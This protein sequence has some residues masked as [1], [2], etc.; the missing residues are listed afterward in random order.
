MR[1]FELFAAA[2]ALATAT[3]AF[4]ADTAVATATP[5]FGVDT[6]VKPDASGGTSVSV[7]SGIDYSTGKYGEAK[8]TD[9]L[10]GLTNLSV[11]SHDFT[12]SASLPYLTIAGPAFVV[13]GPGG[14][15]VL[16]KPRPGTDSAGRSGW[17]DLSLGV[18]YTLPAELLDDFEVAVTE[19]TK[20]ATADASKGLSTGATDFS[21][22]VDVSRQ[23]DIWSPFVNFGYHVPGKPS[24]YSFDDAPSFS[25]GTSVA[26]GSDLVAIASYDFDG[27]IS[28]TL[29]DA[30]QLFGS[31]T[32]LAT[33][34]ISLTAYADY[35]LSSGA[36]KVGTGLFISWKVR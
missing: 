13:V 6:A 29:A 11:T 3:P 18:S 7:S 12:L 22:Y 8:S 33:N 35:G 26:L 23:F 30:Q 19:R 27:S 1:R 2:I 20:V 36:P 25:V 4:A 31:M 14:V 10:V 17:G 34:D 5:A 21:F 28:S 32:W 16:I 24:F 15:P 9:I